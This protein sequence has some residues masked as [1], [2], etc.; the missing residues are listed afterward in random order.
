MAILSLHP[1]SFW[2]CCSLSGLD[3]HSAK[4]LSALKYPFPSVS[5]VATQP[6]GLG[7]HSVLEILIIIL[8]ARLLIILLGG[9]SDNN[10]ANN[11]IN[12]D[13]ELSC[14]QTSVNDKN[15][16]PHNHLIIKVSRYKLYRD[17][18]KIKKKKRKKGITSWPRNS[19]NAARVRVRLN[20]RKHYLLLDIFFIYSIK[21][22]YF[23]VCFVCF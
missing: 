10:D 8:V 20:T 3:F 13:Y 11:D 5:L 15:E 12:I 19:H 21:Y 16:S 6:W 2:Q 17:L 7:I 23:F 14:I 1:G 9:K 18:F 4:Q 22:L